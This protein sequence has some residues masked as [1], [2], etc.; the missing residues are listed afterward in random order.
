MHASLTAT[1]QVF[2][3]THRIKITDDFVEEKRKLLIL[4]LSMVLLIMVWLN[5]CH[6]YPNEGYPRFHYCAAFKKF[7]EIKGSHVD[8]NNLK[9]VSYKVVLRIYSGRGIH[10]RSEA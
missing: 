3:L 1:S 10:L 7:P 2:G 9:L 6:R 4:V 5:K 8:L